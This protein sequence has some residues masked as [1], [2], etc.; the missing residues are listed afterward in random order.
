MAS[1]IWVL[2][3]LGGFC[4][5]SWCGPALPRMLA[6]GR[7]PAS[8]V[9]RVR[10]SLTWNLPFLRFLFP[11]EGFSH[12]SG[13]GGAIVLQPGFSYLLKMIDWTSRW[14]PEAVSLASITAESCERA[15]ISSWI[16][17]FGVPALVISDFGS[18]FMSSVWSEVCSILGISP[19]RT[20][21]FHFK[22]IRMI[23]VPRFPQEA[24][25]ASAD[26]VKHLPLVMLGLR[27]ALWDN[28]GFGLAESV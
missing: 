5:L 21:S 6:S 26:W 9:N 8:G 3:L 1:P 25:F 27:S 20:K 17:Q 28:F 22:S 12:S 19:V 14:R 13:S 4:P 7:G 15:F 24:R 11:E 16:A 23:E 10:S 18:Q 2:E